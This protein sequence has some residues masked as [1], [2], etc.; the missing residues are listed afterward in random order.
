MGRLSEALLA[1]QPFD[2]TTYVHARDHGRL[3]A[4]LNQVR[5]V[6][7]DRQWHMLAEI[8]LRVRGSEAGVSAR[9]RDLRKTKFGGHLIERRHI[10]HGV[11]QYR[12]A[13]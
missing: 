6:L 9:I 7:S 12:M 5:Q 4:Q 8:V 1:D 11:W 2:G 3:S 10:S 13:D